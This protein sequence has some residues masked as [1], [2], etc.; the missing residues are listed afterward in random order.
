M[1]V[2]LYCTTASCA[3]IFKYFQHSGEE[4]YVYAFRSSIYCTVLIVFYDCLCVCLLLVV[5]DADPL[6][7]TLPVF[8]SRR[9]LPRVL[10]A[11]ASK[12]VCFAVKDALALASDVRVVR[13]ACLRHFGQEG[14]TQAADGLTETQFQA[15]CV[16][17]ANEKAFGNFSELAENKGLA[18]AVYSRCTRVPC[19][20]FF[21]HAS[22]TAVYVSIN[23]GIEQ[24]VRP[25]K[26]VFCFCIVLFLFFVF[27]RDCGCP[28][29]GGSRCH[30]ALQDKRTLPP[31]A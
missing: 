8:R 12:P 14:G 29:L 6:L 15:A 5:H 30:L 27:S 25:Q 11:R 9:I 19:L 17:L 3:A 2:R 28:L 22:Q 20:V 23:R 24:F 31:P 16:D 18:A 13:D 7:Y 1:V 26:N 4:V 10:A 21:L